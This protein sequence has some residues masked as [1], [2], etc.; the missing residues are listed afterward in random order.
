MSMIS[1]GAGHATHSNADSSFLSQ[2][3]SSSKAIGL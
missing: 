1:F 3:G 2:L